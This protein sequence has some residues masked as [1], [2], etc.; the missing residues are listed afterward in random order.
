[1]CALEQR[2]LA[3]ATVLI[4]G[5]TGDVG[6][7]CARCLAPFV[8]RL[9]LRARNQARLN[10]LAAHLQADGCQIDT[11]C[12][13]QQFDLQADIVICAASLPSPSFVL[14]GISPGAIVCD[15][16][17]PKNLSPLASHQAKVFYGGLG[18]VTGDLRLSPDLNGILNRHPFP[19][20]VHGCLLEGI[21]LAL[22]NRFEPFSQRRGFITRGRVA[23]MEKIA[24]RHGIVLAP[25]F[26]SDGPVEL[27]QS[28]R[29][30]MDSRAE[31]NQFSYA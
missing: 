9:Q 30:G 14:N 3:E 17:Y 23:E 21:S 29:Q 24:A 2:D 22:E 31:L 27:F 16:G 7:G 10:T 6:S 12:G 11:A 5:A 1:M 18:Q 15:A 25:L 28:A 13:P 4:I 20:V 26:N 8:T 19:N